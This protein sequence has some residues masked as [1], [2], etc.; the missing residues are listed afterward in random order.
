MNKKVGVVK[1]IVYKAYKDDIQQIVYFCKNCN[2]SAENS[3]AGLL[4][5]I[6]VS[7][8]F[9]DADDIAKAF[10]NFCPTCDKPLDWNNMICKTSRMSN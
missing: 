5:R 4:Q 7:C 1:K 9:D 6:E 10:T 2:E 8:L 3:K